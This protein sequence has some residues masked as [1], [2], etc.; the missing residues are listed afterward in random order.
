VR[1]AAARVL[2]GRPEKAASPDGEAALPSVD[3]LAGDE[4]TLV[5]A[6]AVHLW[7]ERYGPARRCVNAAIDRLRSGSSA[8]LLSLAL[9]VRS[10]LSFRTGGWAT[11][12]ADAVESVSCADRAAANG[13]VT[14]GLI[15]LARLEATTGDAD[16]L[17][18]RL[19]RSRREAGPYEVGLRLLLE[20]AVA[21]LAALGAGEPARAVEAL[22]EAWRQAIALGVGHPNV[23]PFAA[24][25]AEALV[26]CGQ[27]ERALEVMAW[28][29]ER[30]D[31][32]RLSLPLAGL[33]R[34]RALLADD[35][36]QAA[37]A[38]GAALA[39]CETGSTPFELARTLLCEGEVLRRH[40][41]P[42]ASRAGLR[43][44]V[45]LFEQ[46]GA[47]A[48]AER[49]GAE[50]FA[51]GD[52]ERVRPVPA[53]TEPLSAQQLEIARLVASGRN[54]VEVAQAVFL[55]RKTVETHLTHIYRKLGIRSRTQLASALLFLAPGPIAEPRVPEVRV[56][57]VRAA[58]PR[59][60]EPR[61]PEGA[62]PDPA[63]DRRAAV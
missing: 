44:A 15:A 19:V 60:V 39:A 26:R 52:R 62:E 37:T 13:T 22:E 7:A 27:R 45:R 41:R 25:L 38:I 3:E 30:A 42:G 32:L 1:L 31:T 55:S 58:E 16:L 2:A 61:S 46:L 12:Q 21:G 51:S 33:G 29:Q 11:A 36:P 23:V 34:C 49:A 28:L 48:W 10:E 14:F 4:L 47:T 17:G 43:R 50:L 63:L 8:S 35:G 54:N 6:A 53:G 57:E 24:D 59:A 5:L 56:P 18:Q 40:H 20:P 9:S